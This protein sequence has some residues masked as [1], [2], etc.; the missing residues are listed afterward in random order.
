MKKINKNEKTTIEILREIRDKIGEEIKDM[1]R[2]Q[3]SIY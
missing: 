2:K 1:D 3:L